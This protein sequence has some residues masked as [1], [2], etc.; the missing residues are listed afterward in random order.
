[1]VKVRKHLLLRS[2]SKFGITAGILFY[3][4]LNNFQVF[5]VKNS[6]FLTYLNFTM[7]T[8]G[9]YNCFNI[10][11]KKRFEKAFKKICGN[12][13]KIKNQSRVTLGALSPHAISIF[14]VILTRTHAIRS[15]L[16]Y[17]LMVTRSHYY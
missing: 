16:C 8:F 13:T 2:F 5:V 9:V 3:L 14:P 7:F 17:L 10:F 15:R 12:L 11:G 1:M 6:F 4:I